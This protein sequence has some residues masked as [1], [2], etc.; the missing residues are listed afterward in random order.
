MRLGARLACPSCGRAVA[1]RWIQGR[2]TA[3][4]QCPSCGHVFE[5]TWPGWDFE[6]E[7]V[8]VYPP[9]QEP[10]RGAA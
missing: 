4:Q 7:T 1:C 8:V 2:E 5:A 10:G 9:G 6:P 3:D